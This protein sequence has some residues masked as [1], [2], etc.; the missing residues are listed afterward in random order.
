MRFASRGQAASKAIRLGPRSNGTNP[1]VRGSHASTANAMTPSGTSTIRIAGAPSSGRRP[2]FAPGILL[3][4]VGAFKRAEREAG[5]EIFGRC[6]A[7]RLDE[8]RVWSSAKRLS[9]P[10]ESRA[11]E[12]DHHRPSYDTRVHPAEATP[13]QPAVPASHERSTLAVAPAA[14]TQ[15]LA[16]AGIFWLGG[17]WV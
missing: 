7:A 13:S 16:C 8:I 5:R 10:P 17:G 2:R 11:M 9:R 4:R 14:S 3:W 1:W 12:Q 15:E 6:V